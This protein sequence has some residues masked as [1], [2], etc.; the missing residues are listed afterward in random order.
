MRAST[1]QV[2]DNSNCCDSQIVEEHSHPSACH[3]AV[4]TKRRRTLDS[5]INMLLAMMRPMMEINNHS[6]LR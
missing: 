1:K 3:T 5:T 2:E 4:S 6:M